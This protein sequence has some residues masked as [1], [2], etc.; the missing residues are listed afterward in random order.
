MEGEGPRDRLTCRSR[1]RAGCQSVYRQGRDRHQTPCAHAG[2]RPHTSQRSSAFSS[3]LLSSN[4][5]EM[6]PQ[7]TIVNSFTRFRLS[8]RAA[9][10][11]VTE[12]GAVVTEA[13]AEVTE[14]AGVVDAKCLSAVQRYARL[15]RQRWHRSWTA[16]RYNDELL[17]GRARC[18][19]LGPAGSWSR[20]SVPAD[21]SPRA[22]RNRGVLRRRDACAPPTRRARGTVDRGGLGVSAFARST[23]DAPGA[24]S[25][26]MVHA[27]DHTGRFRRTTVP[28]RLSAPIDR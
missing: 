25:A 28:V 2:A 1:F 14:I 26:L 24:K 9:G 22:R 5:R 23:L 7:R 13:E 27:W 11:G 12:A 6:T 4:S 8:A 19:Q 10:A 20:G 18:R 15:R 16:T 3:Q 21:C 17:H